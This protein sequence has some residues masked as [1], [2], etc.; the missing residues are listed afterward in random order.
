MHRLLMTNFYRL[1]KEKTFWLMLVGM[2]LLGIYFYFNNYLPN[3]VNC[4]N[5]VGAVLFSFNVIGGILVAIFTTNFVGTEYGNGTLRN[6]L[7]CGHSRA[8]IYLSNLITCSL[9]AVAFDLVF[10]GAV[11]LTGAIFLFSVTTPVET[12]LYMMGTSLLLSVSFASVYTFITMNISNKSAS[13][14]VALSLKIWAFLITSNL[15]HKIANSSG[16]QKTILKF[17]YDFIPSGQAFQL[18]NLRGDLKTMCLY[19]AILFLFTT[20]FGLYIFDKKHLQ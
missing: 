2:F 4:E 3:C 10:I 1:K 15:S 13:A 16:V 5:E 7:I 8:S 17:I 14:I 18:T 20:S 19:S 9:V 12:V 11:L 6:K